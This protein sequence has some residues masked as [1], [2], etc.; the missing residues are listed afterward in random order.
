MAGSSVQGFGVAAPPSTIAATDRCGLPVP[1]ASVL[2][3]GGAG[4]LSVLFCKPF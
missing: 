2:S 4:R 3:S 1:T